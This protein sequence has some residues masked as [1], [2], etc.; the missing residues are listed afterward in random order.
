MA[1]CNGQG[2]CLHQCICEC[3]DADNEDV[4]SEICICGHRD[5]PKLI[6]GTDYYDSY[7]KSDCPYNCQLVRCH[8]YRLCGQTRPK[9][10]LNCDGGMC[11]DCAL[12]IGK[13]KFLDV[14]DDCP[15]CLNNKDII[16]VCCGK[17]NICI[18]CWKEWSRTSK[19]I[20]LTCP[21]CRDHIWNWSKKR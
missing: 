14:K 18:D 2:D 13:I 5:H 17:H 4:P 20:P 10:L 15:I 3:F 16:Q 7:Y 1:S 12:K 21:I 9:W 8:N 6:G 11:K 19:Q